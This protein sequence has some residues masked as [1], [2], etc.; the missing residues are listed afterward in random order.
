M[1][2]LKSTCTAFLLLFSINFFGQTSYPVGVYMSQEELLTK[3]PSEQYDLTIEPLKNEI[4]YHIRSPEKEV[5]RKVINRK[6]WAISDGEALYLNGY[7]IEF[8]P[9]YLKVLNEGKYLLYV[10]SLKAS[11]AGMIAFGGGL[12]ASTIAAQSRWL[13]AWNPETLENFKINKQVLEQWL[14]KTP[15]LLTDYQYEALPREMDVIIRYASLRNAAYDESEA[16]D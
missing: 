12:I 9:Q 4:N 14:E 7:Q 13:Y 16:V 5:K 15:W 3:S 8:E 1:S 6:I 2:T 11:D 10:G